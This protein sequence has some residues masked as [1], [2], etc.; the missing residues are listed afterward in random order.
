MEKIHMKITDAQLNEHADRLG[1]VLTA[2]YERYDVKIPFIVVSGEY[3]GCTGRISYTG[4]RRAKQL[5]YHSLDLS[6]RK[7]YWEH[8]AKE[9]G[10]VI[11]EHDASYRVNVPITIQDRYGKV[12]KTDFTTLRRS[13]RTIY[14]MSYGEL[15]VTTLLRENDIPFNSQVPVNT[16]LGKQ[17]LDFLVVTPQGR[18]AIEYNGIQHYEESGY[19]SRDLLT[20]RNYDLAKKEY[21]NVQGIQLIE[22]PYT[23]DTLVSVAKYLNELGVAK[24]PSKPVNLNNRDQQLVHDYIE[25]FMPRKEVAKKYGI[26]EA[27]VSKISRRYGFKRKPINPKSTLL[28]DKSWNILYDY[29]YVGLNRKAVA[30]KY[31]IS[32]ISVTHV[33]MRSGFT[34]SSTGNVCSLAKSN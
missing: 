14:G 16:K 6:S 29:L 8:I 19:F 23:A 28:A 18:V 17:F 31:G 2:P 25:R 1:I 13:K 9:R 32:L 24:I 3:E 12:V 30:D 27:T 33:A 21:C 5:S 15:L 20:Q 7:K 22:I 11:L 4:L 26:S 34:K 10:C